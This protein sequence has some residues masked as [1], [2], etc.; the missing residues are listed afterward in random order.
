MGQVQ[1]RKRERTIDKEDDGKPANEVRGYKLF[2]LLIPS[3]YRMVNRTGG[4]HSPRC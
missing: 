1:E 2:R 3:R 4:R